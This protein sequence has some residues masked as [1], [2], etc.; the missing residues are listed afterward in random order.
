VSIKSAAY[1]GNKGSPLCPTFTS[2][3]VKIVRFKG[4]LNDYLNCRKR[5]F[6]V[7]CP[8]TKPLSEGRKLYYYYDLNALLCA[9]KQG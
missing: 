9:Q 8:L 1:E 7:A 5:G 4:K 6:L 2:G 3:I